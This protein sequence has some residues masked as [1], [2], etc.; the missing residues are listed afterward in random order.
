MKAILVIYLTITVCSILRD[1]SSQAEA[2]SGAASGSHSETCCGAETDQDDDKGKEQSPRSRQRVL[3]SRDLERR[4]QSR[5]EERIARRAPGW[6]DTAKLDR[7]ADWD[8]HWGA[9]AR[10]GRGWRHGLLVGH[11]FWACEARPA[12]VGL[13]YGPCFLRNKK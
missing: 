5:N 7:L 1:R 8:L 9:G 11:H 10:G 6:R 13:I 3:T 12:N 2:K 4:L